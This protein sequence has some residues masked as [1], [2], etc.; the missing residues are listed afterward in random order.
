MRSG[1]NGEVWGKR[2]NAKRL[3]AYA[4]DVQPYPAA[5]SAWLFLDSVA[6]SFRVLMVMVLIW[7]EA[8]VMGRVDSQMI[9]SRQGEA[10]VLGIPKYLEYGIIFLD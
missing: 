2:R 8:V 10:F 5:R 1:E 4:C 6:S 9:V 7:T 3:N